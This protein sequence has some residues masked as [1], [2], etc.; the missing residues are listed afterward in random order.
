MP[1]NGNFEAKKEHAEKK[2]KKKSVFFERKRVFE[3]RI[4]LPAQIFIASLILFDK[5][6]YRPC[7]P[8]QRGYG[9][10]QKTKNTQVDRK[11]REK[12]TTLKIKTKRKGTERTTQE[13]T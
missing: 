5:C 7:I 6:P 4:E 10:C 2:K 13:S 12:K 8:G 1:K 9:I 11:K 3:V